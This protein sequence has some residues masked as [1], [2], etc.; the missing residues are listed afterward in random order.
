MRSR[1]RAQLH[2]VS[3]PK[4]P[5]SGTSPACRARRSCIAFRSVRPWLALDYR[6]MPLHFFV[7]RTLRRLPA[8]TTPTAVALV[9]AGLGPGCF[10]ANTEYQRARAKAVRDAV[11]AHRYAGTESSV[12][13]DTENTLTDQGFTVTSGDT[14]QW[15]SMDADR[16]ERVR[17]SLHGHHGIA[18]QLFS[19]TETLSPQRFETK[20]RARRGDLERKLLEA[21]APEAAKTASDDD[22]S[23]F[24]YDLPA[25]Q[26][27]GQI[28]SVA[29]D[30]GYHLD[31]YAAPIDS[32]GSSLW[33]TDASSEHRHRLDV[34]VTKQQH[35][36]YTLTIHQLDEVAV[37]ERTWEGHREARDH[38]LELAVIAHVDPTRAQAISDDADEAGQQAYDDAIDRGAMSCG[39]RG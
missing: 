19:Q 37:G 10:C 28:A 7:G 5:E 18:V 3:S 34:H 6:D 33:V 39:R 38:D 13:G 35:R 12:R 2:G 1:V 30:D 20:S 21:L 16:R 25:D 27:W 9:S 11:D 15:R 17:I 32:T 14:T 36:Q 26:L 31:R 8:W 22:V 24:E 4:L 23:N 29:Q